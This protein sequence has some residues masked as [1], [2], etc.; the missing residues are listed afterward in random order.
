MSA[1]DIIFLQSSLL[2]FIEEIDKS[3]FLFINTQLT[4]A[5]GDF[6]FPILRFPKTWIPLYLALLVFVIWKFKKKAIPWIIF[7]IICITLTDQISSHVLKGYFGRLRPC[8]D[9][10]IKDIARLLVSRCPGNASFTSSHAVNHFG[11]AA[12]F[13]YSLKN[14]LK[15]W[16]WLFFVWA[17]SICYAQVYVGVHY[18]GDVIAGGVLGFLLGGFV[19]YFFKKYFDFPKISKK[20]KGI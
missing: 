14:Y 6:I 10:S 3:V 11:I 17:A 12:F 15:G 18:P 4:G 8:Q 20:T 16:G 1:F 2:S 7:G 5:I 19:V 9:A 13:Y